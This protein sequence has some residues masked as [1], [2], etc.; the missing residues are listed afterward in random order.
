MVQ[1]CVAFGANLGE[2]Q[3]TVLQAIQDVG[4]LAN[5]Q[6]RIASSLY[7]SAPY[8]AIGPEFVNAVA[9]YDTDLPPLELLDALQ[10][11]ETIAGRERPFLNAP[12]TLDL[13]IIFYG[14]VALDSPRLTLPHP[15]WQGRAFVLVPLAEI[16][17]EKVSP[18]LLSSFA[19]QPVSRIG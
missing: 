4:A 12:R 11:L 5:T 14:D 18:A 19:N 7:A 1:V 3:A 16:S 6:L 9:M 15:R 10:N 2:A 8:E 13:D 17:P